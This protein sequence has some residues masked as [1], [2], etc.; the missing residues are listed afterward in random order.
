M[1]KYLTPQAYR[2]SDQ[3]IYNTSSA[4]LDS[5]LA[6]QIELAEGAI[7]A[8]MGFR[9]QTPSGFAPG[10]IALMQAG[11]R[12]NPT[13]IRFPLP[14]TPIRR[15]TR[16]RIHLTNATDGSAVIGTLSPNEV[17]F[18]QDEQYA[19]ITSQTLAYS[20]ATP[21]IGFSLR[22][23]LMELD[24]ECGFYLSFLGE[25]LYNDS[26]DLKTYNSLKQFW[27]STYVQAIGNQPNV[28]PP[29]PPVIYV[30]GIVTSASNYAVNYAEGQVVFTAA[31]ASS[32]V[33]T[34]D[35]AGTIPALVKNACIEQVNHLL[36][37]R[38]LRQQGAG[39]LMMVKMGKREIR[40]SPKLNIDEDYLCDA[41]RTKLRGYKAW[42]A[43]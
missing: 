15:V 39:G 30:N 22:P 43:G 27:A 29:V 5:F 2:R 3:G 8:F 11:L 34:A 4:V 12:P 24:G 13:K 20:V 35:F 17:V 23:P 18:N 36:E 25:T 33:I 26:G 31:R 40:R 38:I 37:Q 14:P 10:T 41:A 9:L 19:E 6:Q 7:D 21:L 28:L 16:L 32:D 42:P 1:P